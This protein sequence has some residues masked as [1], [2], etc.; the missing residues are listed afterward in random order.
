MVIRTLMI[1]RLLLSG[2]GEKR[3]ERNGVRNHK[4]T[5]TIFIGHSD[6]ASPN[7]AIGQD[8]RQALIYQLPSRRKMVP[9]TL[10]AAPPFQPPAHYDAYL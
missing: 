4:F 8:R 3:W 1:T 9:D 5:G 7:R 2:C 6:R 10:P